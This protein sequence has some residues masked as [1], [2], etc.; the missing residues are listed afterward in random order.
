M[1]NTLCAMNV[2]KYIIAISMLHIKKQSNMIF[3]CTPITLVQGKIALAFKD[4]LMPVFFDTRQLAA[5]STVLICLSALTACTTD[6]GSQASV[7]GRMIEGRTLAARAGF[8]TTVGEPKD[9][10]VRSRLKSDYAYPEIT[11]TPA[12][13]SLARRTPEEIKVLEGRLDAS[14]N[15]STALAKR[16]VPKSSYGGVA[17]AR[18]AALA[19]RARANKPIYAPGNPQPTSYPVPE[20]RRSNRPKMSNP[21]AIPRD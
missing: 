15:R 6:Q 13:R 11:P 17:E 16:P 4:C 1:I 19:A 14:R 10:V 5:I 21:L 20:S 18:R 9:F 7:E 2:S 3:A 8:T 12:E